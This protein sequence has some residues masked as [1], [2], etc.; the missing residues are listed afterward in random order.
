MSDDRKKIRVQAIRQQYKQFHPG[1]EPV[2]LWVLRDQLS[3]IAVFLSGMDPVPAEPNYPSLVDE[4]LELIRF[5]RAVFA[6]E[7]PVV[8]RPTNDDDSPLPRNWLAEGR[9]W[10]AKG[11]WPRYRNFLAGTRSPA[12]LKALDTVTDSIIGHSGTPEWTVDSWDRRGVVVGQVQSGKTETYIGVLAKA[13]DA[14]Y[15][16]IVVLAGIHNDLRAQTQLRLDEGIVGT[17]LLDNELFRRVP[18]GVG[19]LPA[20]QRDVAAELVVM[21]SGQANG[22]FSRAVANRYTNPAH[23]HLWIIKKNVS[24]L[25]LLNEFFA[26]NPAATAQPLFLLDDE[27]DQASVNTNEDND[28]TKTNREIRNLLG[29]FK[30]SSYVGMTATPFANIFIHPDSANEEQGEDLFPKDFILRI[31]PSPEYFGPDRLFAIGEDGGDDDVNIAPRLVFQADDWDTWIKPRH[32]RTYQPGPLP[33]SLLQALADFVVGAAI[34][35]LRFGVPGELGFDSEVKSHATMLVHVTRYVDVQKEVTAQIQSEAKR[36]RAELIGGSDQAASWGNRVR[37]AFERIVE[38]GAQLKASLSPDQQEWAIGRQ[39]DYPTVLSTVRS[40]LAE[41][42]VAEVNGTVEDGLRYRTAE[43]RFVVAIGG[44][45]L[46][47]GLTLEGL[48]VSYFLRS[49]G[50]WDTLMQM[51]RWFGYRPRYL[52]LCRVYMPTDLSLTYEEVTRAI[53]DLS[54]QFDTMAAA[55]ASPLDFGLRLPKLATGQLPTRK[56]AMAHVEVGLEAFHSETLLEKLL[57]PTSGSALDRAHDAL[58][59][60]FSACSNVNTLVHLGNTDVKTRTQGF[61]GVSPS[62]IIEFLKG[63]GLPIARLE[64]PTDALCEYIEAQVKQG[65]LIDWTV[66][67]VG[68]NDDPGDGR[69]T[70]KIG[71]L[72]LTPSMH[73]TH[74]EG[75]ETR[76]LRRIKNLS[77]LRDETLDLSLEEYRS[78]LA[79]AEVRGTA[80]KRSDF[81]SKRDPKRALLLCYPVVDEKRDAN[82]PV[83]IT[84]AI[85]FPRIEGEVRTEYYIT[86]AEIRR[87]I[88]IDDEETEETND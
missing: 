76:P 26:Q 1:D 66:A 29:Q 35:R 9:S 33:E 78:A 69:P 75:G 57:F 8:M 7:P 18:I 83:S 37:H 63:A 45:K 41:L 60:L 88:G 42:E 72:E 54:R 67:F 43:N 3:K 24:R 59:R 47:R 48:T 61:R 51:G 39:F 62:V 80:V 79:A 32:K 22:D 13:I 70:H 27:S 81:R 49:A 64:E 12:K 28:P 23:A 73:T 14:G 38:T 86:P 6:P 31:K 25:K 50:T 40:M 34:K 56:G 10:N 4:A 87:R 19:L 65:R 44:D 2:E 21:T 82:S 11:Y 74:P 17:T 30:K 58:E 36:M 55:G 77:S 84:W 85:S 15:K 68:L 20:F 53:N 16:S 46:S 52:D 5:E 71:S